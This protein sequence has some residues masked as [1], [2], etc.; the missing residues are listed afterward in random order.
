MKLLAARRATV[1][2]ATVAIT[3]TTTIAV[4]GIVAHGSKVGCRFRER[5]LAPELELG[6]NGDM[7]R[8]EVGVREA[9]TPTHVLLLHASQQSQDVQEVGRVINIVDHRHKRGC[10][11]GERQLVNLAVR[12]SKCHLVRESVRRVASVGMISKIVVALC[13]RSLGQ[14]LVHTRVWLRVEI[15]TDQG[16]QLAAYTV[17]SGGC[18]RGSWQ[19]GPLV[20]KLVQLVH[21]HGNLNQLDVLEN[22]V[23]VDMGIGDHH[24][25]VCI[26]VLQEGDDRDVVLSHDAVEDVLCLPE[27]WSLESN[28]VELYQMLIDQGEPNNVIEKRIVRTWL[29]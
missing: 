11:V 27:V 17:N 15:S 23:P 14:E 16:R 7:V 5:D 4:A 21:Q 3:I 9:D 2:A 10:K 13:D 26:L 8:W 19:M 12:R 20:R 22:R 29:Q 24:P 1:V 6:Q 25:V 18:A 28:M